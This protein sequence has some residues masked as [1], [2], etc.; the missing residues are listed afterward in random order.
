MMFQF[1]FFMVGLAV[2][3]KVECFVIEFHAAPLLFVAMSSRLSNTAAAAYPLL[4]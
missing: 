3:I 4:Y 1:L 2:P